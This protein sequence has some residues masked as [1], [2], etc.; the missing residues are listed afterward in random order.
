MTA[1]VPASD[2]TRK[3]IADVLSGDFDQSAL[4]RNAVRLIIEEALEAEVTDVLGRGDYERGEP[5]GYRNGNRLGRLKTAEGIV[6]YAVPRVTGTAEPWAS[7]V[8]QALSGRTEALERLVVERYA[9]GL[10]MRDIEAAF[11]GADGRCVLTKSAASPVTERWWEDYL[12]FAGRDLAGQPILYRFLDGVAERP[13]GASPASRCWPRGALRP[14]A[15]RCSWACIRRPR[16]TRPRP[17]NARGISRA[18]E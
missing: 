14:R 1:R 13:T 16:K 15:P 4:L 10:S 7:E 17:A 9:R 6:E 18:G 2:R 5:A 12:A 11:T 3:R 8:K